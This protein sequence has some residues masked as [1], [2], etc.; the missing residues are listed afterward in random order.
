MKLLGNNKN[1]I[2]KDKNFENVPNLEITE[3]VLV[4]CNI[5]NSDYQQDSKVLSTFIP[6]ICFAQLLDVS[7]KNFIF[8]KAFNAEFSYFEIWFP[9]QSSKPLEIS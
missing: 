7:P 1:K 8:L 3:L 5:A 6:N 9:D 4:D 2:N